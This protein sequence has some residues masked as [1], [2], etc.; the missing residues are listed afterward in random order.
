MAVRSARWPGGSWP[1]RSLHAGE[2]VA[3]C[4]HRASLVSRRHPA[5]GRKAVDSRQPVRGFSHLQP[6]NGEWRRKVASRSQKRERRP[7]VRGALRR[8]L[9]SPKPRSGEGGPTSRPNEIVL[10]VVYK[11]ISCQRSALSCRR[12]CRE[13]KADG[14]K[15]VHV[16]SSGLRDQ[17]RRSPRV[18]APGKRAAFVRGRRVPAGA[19]HHAFLE[20]VDHVVL[21]AGIEEPDPRRLGG[22]EHTATHRCH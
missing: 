19:D 22:I 7:A 21:V 4:H 13:L 12:R 20:L 11:T 3:R 10:S 9:V 6:A 2:I 5:A 17:E 1:G 15:A 18:G 16:D 14:G 8:S